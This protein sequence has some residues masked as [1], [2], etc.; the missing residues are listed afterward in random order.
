MPPLASLNR[1]TFAR[2]AHQAQRL[3][4]IWIRRW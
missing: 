3:G 4:S 2:T 1:G